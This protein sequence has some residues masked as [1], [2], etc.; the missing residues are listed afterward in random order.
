LAAV[1]SA[2]FAGN[3]FEFVKL[4]VVTAVTMENVVFWDVKP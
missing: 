1:V 2:T 3:L 4:E